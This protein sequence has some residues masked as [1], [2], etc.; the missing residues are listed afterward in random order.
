MTIV[1][2]SIFNKHSSTLIMSPLFCYKRSCNLTV[3]FIIQQQASASATVFH[4]SSPFNT[5]LSTSSCTPSKLS[6]LLHLSFPSVPLLPVPWSVV[7]V[8]LEI[9]SVPTAVLT[10][11]TTDFGSTLLSVPRELAVFPTTGNVYKMTVTPMFSPK[12]THRL[13]PFSVSRLLLQ[14]PAPRLWN[15]TADA[16]IP[17]TTLAP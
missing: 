11:A 3:I 8:L 10:C 15:G 4:F 16:T 2:S 9:T 12:S 14:V 5:L 6:S 7:N 17:A 13:R 1:T